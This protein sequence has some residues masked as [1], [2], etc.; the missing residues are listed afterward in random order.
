VA[1]I[2]MVCEKPAYSFPSQLQGL[3]IPPDVS[4]IFVDSVPMV[5]WWSYK[6]HCAE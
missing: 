3:I 2:D 4:V 5:T 1:S 6:L